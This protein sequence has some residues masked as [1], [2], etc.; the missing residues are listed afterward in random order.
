MIGS[1]FLI[2]LTVADFQ[3]S[4]TWYRDV[5][6]LPLLL[7]KD[8][9]HF[10]MFEAGSTRLALKGGTPQPGS[11]LLTFEVKDLAGQV[12][13]LRARGA[14]IEGTIKVSPEGYRRVRLRDPDGYALSLFEWLRE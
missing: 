2:E 10:A 7:R 11:V 4:V 12:E 13:Q 14:I 6:V 9:E 8:A 5:L 3:A 1:L